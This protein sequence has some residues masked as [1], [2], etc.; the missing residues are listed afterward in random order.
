MQNG[1]ADLTQLRHMTFAAPIYDLVLSQHTNTWDKYFEF[2][3]YLYISDFGLLWF[4]FLD[5]FH[6]VDSLCCNC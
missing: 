2:Q 4:L 5:C 1:I 6:L 3:L